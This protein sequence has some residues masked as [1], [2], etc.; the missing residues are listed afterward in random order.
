M[1][2]KKHLCSLSDIT[3][4]LMLKCMIVVTLLFTST[5]AFSEA[6]VT[7]FPFAENFDADNY[8]N[9]VYTDKG[10]RHEWKSNEGWQGS[11][12]AKFYPN[13]TDNGYMGLGQF[14]HFNNN[15]GVEQL[16]VRFL[17]YYGSEWNPGGHQNKI[18][19]M[20]R[21]SD[22]EYDNQ[23]GRPMLVSIAD[24]PENP[25]W[26]TVGVCGS[27]L[28]A[29]EG[30]L[31]WPDGNDSF[32]ITPPP[33]GRTGEWVSVEMEANTR[34]GEVKVYIHTRD[35]ELSGVYAHYMLE[36]LGYPF[37]YIDIIGG[38]N[39]DQAVSSPNNYYMI[40]ELEI[41]DSYIGPPAGFL[42]GENPPPQ[43]TAN[44]YVIQNPALVSA[45]VISLADN[46]VITA[47][48]RTLNLD[49]YETGNFPSNTGHFA[50]GMVITGTGPFEMGSNT[51]ATDMPTHASMLGTEFVMPHVRYSHLYYLVSPNGNTTAQISV[52]GLQYQLT[53]PQGEVVE[54]NAGIVK[55]VSTVITS[56]APILV[57]HRGDPMEASWYADAS[58]VSPAAT[59]LWGIRSK[60]A[61]IGAVEDN[62]HVHMYSSNGLHSYTTLQSGQIRYVNVGDRTGQGQGNAIHL[63][64]DK[65]I[66]AIQIGDGDG[67]D[68]TAF[69]PTSLL[70][71]RFGVPRDAQ[72]I[73]IACPEANTSIT[74][75]NGS[76]PPVT[77]S[78]NT[79]GNYPGKAYFG[80]NSNGTHIQFGAYFE[81]NNPVY[82]I[83]EAS[84]SNDEHNMLGTDSYVAP[85]FSTD[86]EG[87]FPVNDW[88]D[89][90]VSQSG[91]GAT[92][93]FPQTQNSRVAQF[94]LRAGSSNEVWLR[95]NF[96]AYPGINDEP[97]SELWLNFEYMIN[98]TSIY[99]PNVDQASKILYFNWS[100]PGNK[101]RTSQVVLSAMNNGNGHRFRLSKEIFNA[102]GQWIPGGEYL[103]EYSPETIPVNQKLY[104]QL[105]IRNSTNGAANGLVQLY[106]NGDLILERRNVVLNENSG[107]SPTQLVLTPQISHTPPGSAANGY[108]QYDNVSLYDS[109][110]G[111]FTAP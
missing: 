35:G 42:D 71:R 90:R 75:Y 67:A 82:A 107:H 43:L 14:T 110:P 11:G 88:V 7:S 61:I 31:N 48:N 102:S 105:H 109:N 41:N 86:M 81:S 78:C 68:Q 83:Y 51:L 45:G 64:A 66:G 17:V 70:K 72:Y 15:Q 55:N 44:S 98:T 19:I 84:S 96:G 54:F 89:R 2:C 25:S 10:A 91:G 4:R 56:E 46:N 16:N 1:Y 37:R 20:N 32:K 24:D 39:N 97:V 13:T 50:Q 79:N 27:E 87:S 30:G 3:A 85:V 69:F 62:T 80:S 60:A 6:L 8:E 94:N 77:R 92:I 18:V 101:T 38:Y 93:T 111:F 28:C 58:P 9:I 53:L 33:E 100:R 74:L 65:P 34:T 63:V 57:M 106:S 36:E 23:Q 52:D 5:A 76:N 29:Y 73:A 103:G 95:H 59:E 49:L 40:D 12:A 108:S 21:S 104:L 47:G 26:R 22:P 99:N